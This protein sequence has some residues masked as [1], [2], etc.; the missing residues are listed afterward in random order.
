MFFKKMRDDF[1]I[2]P[3]QKC[4]A[5]LLE[6]TFYLFVIFDNAVVHHPHVACAILVRMGVHLRRFSVSRPAQMRDTARAKKSGRH[7]APQMR[8]RADRFHTPRLRRVY[9]G[10]IIAAV[11]KRRESVEQYFARIS[12]SR[13][14]ENAAHSGTLSRLSQRLKTRR[15]NH[16]SG[17]AFF[18]S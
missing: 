8:Y 18:I 17:Y 5:R 15:N 10:G 11:L 9:A 13:I 3:R 6:T 7:F 14:R 1:G 16:A 12:V 2:R 4:M